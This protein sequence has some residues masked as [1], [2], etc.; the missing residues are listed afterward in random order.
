MFKS[1]CVKIVRV[2]NNSL[3]IIINNKRIEKIVKK[4]DSILN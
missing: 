3:Y 2:I 1:L 4:T